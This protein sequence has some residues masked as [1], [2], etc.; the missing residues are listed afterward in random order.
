MNLSEADQLKI[1]NKSAQ[2]G[3]AHRLLPIKTISNVAIETW[4]HCFVGNLGDAEAM[5]M[6][7]FQYLWRRDDTKK[8]ATIPFRGIAGNIKQLIYLMVDNRINRV[9]TGL[10]VEEWTEVLKLEDFDME[11]VKAVGNNAARAKT[12]DAVKQSLDKIVNYITT[13]YYSSPTILGKATE[14]YFKDHKE[15]R[16]AIDKVYKNAQRYLLEDLCPFFEDGSYI[17]WDAVMKAVKRFYGK[18]ECQETMI[19]RFKALRDVIKSNKRMETKVG[20]FRELLRKFAVDSTDEKDMI[21]GIDF[22]G[23]TRGYN[24]VPERYGAAFNTLF[25]FMVFDKCIPTERWESIQ[26]TYHGYLKEPTYRNWHEKRPE[27]YK[28]IDREARKTAVVTGLVTDENEINYFNSRSARKGNGK[29]FGRNQNKNF[30]K[31]RKTTG[32]KPNSNRPV[33]KRMYKGLNPKLNKFRCKHCSR[34]AKRSI[35]HKGPYGGGSTSNCLFNKQ[36]RRRQGFEAINKAEEDGE[37]DE[38]F[39]ESDQELEENEI[40]Q[41]E[42]SDESSEDEDE[43]DDY[44]S[45]QNEDYS[46]IYQIQEGDYLPAFRDENGDPAMGSYE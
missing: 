5:K 25:T 46:R 4:E 27:L 16:K 36:G 13:D 34:F 32:T 10:T 14:E 7:A 38:N 21:K 3:N 18:D 23:D 35:A 6:E 31:P 42:E 19:D 33:A 40:N 28:I 39:E 45:D 26:T 12:S 2:V 41:A 43:A 15:S 44:E 8:M 22:P 24:T 29:S 30:A 11:D 9:A 1:I 17:S 20:K 37:E